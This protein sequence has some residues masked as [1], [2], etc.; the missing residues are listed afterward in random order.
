MYRNAHQRT[1]DLLM[2]HRADVEKVAKLLLEKEV[3]TRYV[4]VHTICLRIYSRLSSEDMISLLG[5]RP[6]AGRSDDM[7]KWLDE[8]KGSEKSAPRPLEDSEPTPADSPAPVAAAR[9]FEDRI[10]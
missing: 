10:L 3:I 5:K 7:D 1:K 4:G 2:K 9:K 6:F 8:N